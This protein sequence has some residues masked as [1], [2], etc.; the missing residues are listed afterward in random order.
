[1]RF[2]TSHTNPLPLNDRFDENARSLTITIY[3][4]STFHIKLMLRNQRVVFSKYITTSKST[5]FILEEPFTHFIDAII[6]HSLHDA[7]I[8][9]SSWL[10]RKGQS[11]KDIKI[12]FSFPYLNCRS[13]LCFP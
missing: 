7:S 13:L 10:V 11:Q 8:F 12:F 6:S 5:Y 4:T 9:I 3:P 2:K 1:M